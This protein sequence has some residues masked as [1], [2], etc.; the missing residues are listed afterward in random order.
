MILTLSLWA[1]LAAPATPAPDAP[2]YAQC[3]LA[4]YPEHLCGADADA[5]VW[6]D[7]TRMPWR[8]RPA[9]PLDEAALD[10]A[11]LHDQM[12]TPYPVGPWTPPPVGDPGRARSQAFFEKLYGASA[13]AVAA[14]TVKVAWPGGQRLRVSTVAGAHRAL[15]Q[16]AAELAAL[17]K[18]FHRFFDVSA[19][20]FVWRHIKG[21]QRLSMHSFALA[22]D[23]AVKHAH[24]W[25]WAKPDAQGNRPYRNDFPPEV[26]QAFERRGFIWGGKWAHFD[27]MHFEYRPEL[28]HPACAGR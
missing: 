18:R 22:I 9:G 15:A 21:T 27:T 25:R 20:T 13:A 2:A 26:V 28:L 10:Q 11:D 17:P 3:L 19:G 12:A 1:A 4:A 23:V 16:V 24:Y 7:G 8:T 6:C 14:R 5:L